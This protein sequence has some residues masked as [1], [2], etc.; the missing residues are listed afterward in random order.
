MDGTLLDSSSAIIDA[1][2]DGLVNARE[3]MSLPYI[4][5]DL[6]LITN[7]L[8]LPNDEYFQT[9]FPQNSVPEE[10]K[11]D[12]AL[13]YG[14]ESE[15]CEVE[16]IAAGNTKLYPDVYKTLVELKKR[17]HTLKLFTNSN[18]A[19][20]DAIVKTH[21]LDELLSEHL[22]LER[23]RELNI[24]DTKTEMVKLLCP[25]LNNTV[26]VGDRYGDITAGNNCGTITV[27]CSYGF[28]RLEEIKTANY[29]ISSLSELLDIEF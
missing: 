12:F 29:I 23:A 28:G 21:K 26:V 4:E 15:K 11:A 5:P 16:T 2:A 25:D 18:S 27:G 24:A 9:A 6:D 10:L 13:I 17:G 1:V 19:Y 8:G 14:E 20:C 3:K 22:P 7:S